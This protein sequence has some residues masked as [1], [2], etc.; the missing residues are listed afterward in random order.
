MKEKDAVEAGVC[1]QVHL[2]ATVRHFSFHLLPA[3][4]L[5]RNKTSPLGGVQIEAMHCSMLKRY[6][7]FCFLCPQMCVTH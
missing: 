5:Q 7:R 3:E 6:V 4:L 2:S 1:Y